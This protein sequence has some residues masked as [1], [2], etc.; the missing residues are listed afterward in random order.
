ME[1]PL[2][3]IERHRITT[4]GTGVTTL[5]AFYGC[6]LRCKYCLNPQCFAHDTVCRIVTPQELYDY[7]AV[8]NLYF[9]ATGGGITFGGGEPL[10]RSTF[11]REF[12]SIA[13]KEWNI[14]VETALNVDTSNLTETL[15]YVNKYFV[16]I[17]DMDGKTYRAYTSH[18]N[19]RVLANLKLLADNIPPERVTIRLPL[20]PGYNND[21]ARKA[22]MEKLREM[23]FTDF[24]MFTYTTKKRKT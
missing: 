22:S 17:K 21:D 24:D 3:G 23:G 12:C 2:I 8:D 19:N 5:V 11:I 6:P 14:S 16:D 4:D 18:D 7:V 1:A 9:V 13:N 10:L 20:I 15:P